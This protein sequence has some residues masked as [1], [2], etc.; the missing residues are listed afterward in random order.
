MKKLIA[1]VAERRNHSR[2]LWNETVEDSYAWMRDSDSI[3]AFLEKEND[4]T[5]QVLA[6]TEPLQEEIFSE[7]KSRIKESDLSHPVEDGG[8]LY[9][10]KTVEGLAYGIHCRRPVASEATSEQIIL[11]E[12]VEAEGST[13]FDVGV[14][15]I[16]PDHR[17]LLWGAD[18]KGDERYELVLRDIET[19]TDTVLDITGVSTPSTWA[20]DSKHFFYSRPDATNRPYQI[21]GKDISGE[22]DDWLVYEDLD[23]R[24][25]VGV[26]R[27]RDDSF[28]QLTSSSK[29][30]EEVH[31]IDADSPCDAPVCF[32]QRR[33]GIEYAITHKDDFFVVITNENALHFKLMKASDTRYA[34]EPWQELVAHSESE[35]LTGIS[36]LDRYLVIS[37]RIDGYSRLALY[38]W[39]SGETHTVP[40]EEDA[41]TF[42]LGANPSFATTFL[43]YGYGSMTTPAS[44]FSYDFETGDQ[45]LLKQQE[46]LGGY[47]SSD[48]ESSRQW[49]ASAD[50]VKVPISL[51]WKKSMAT[52]QPRPCVFYAYGAYEISLDP[53]FSAFRL[54]LLDRGFVFAMVHA[55]GGGEMGRQWYLD[56]KFASKKNTFADVIAAAEHLIETEMTSSDRLVLRGGSAGGLMAGS[57]INQR[58]ELFAAVVAEVP[59]VDVINT[60]IDETLPL[61]VTEWEEWGNPVASQEAYETMRAY[62]PYENVTAQAYPK[63]LITSGLHDTR[64]AFWE[65]TKWVQALRYNTTSE[66][67]ILLLTE[68][69]S[70]HGGSSGRYDAWREEAKVL[71]FIVDSV[72][73]Q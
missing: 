59:F 73:G 4:Y 11:D 46:V 66:E 63:M 17:L 8:W 1:P 71:A 19:G 30:T 34:S 2:E 41:S 44:L 42:W 36:A 15:S 55:R 48:Y 43:R 31:L 47:D 62:A 23:E 25:F 5:Q 68:M 13:F 40:C 33:E 27:E 65:P 18:R 56:G 50:G 26:S 58:P 70:G 7:V 14:F 67:P 16:S 53:V 64:V 9:Y 10:T 29:I 45:T 20:N 72:Q 57:V 61:T 54:S 37:K 3:E 21:W 39:E 28:I 52:D 12:N 35:M 38:D 32:A 49:A 22:K 6:P 69:S 24:F 60:M 51:V